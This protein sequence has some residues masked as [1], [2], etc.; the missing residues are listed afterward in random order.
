[1]KKLF[2]NKKRAWHL[3]EFAVMETE[4]EFYEY[5]AWQADK[6]TKELSWVRGEARIL[7]DVLV[8][9]SIM[10]EGR[11]E[12]V[13]TMKEVRKEPGGIRRNITVS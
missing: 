11:E 6:K 4:N 9:T 5:M 3:R 8:L 1:M 7:G 2:P 13:K 12:R 10:A